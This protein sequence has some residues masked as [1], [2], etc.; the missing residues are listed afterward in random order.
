MIQRFWGRIRE[1]FTTSFAT[2]LY[3]RVRSAT[4]RWRS[5]YRTPTTNW[6]RSDYDYYNRL[7]RG[8]VKGLEVS[9]LLLKPIISK[10]TSW[11]LG[12]VPNWKT[13]NET[14]Q[15][16]LMDWW[17]DHHPDILRAWRDALK[18]GDSVLV[19][20]SDL[21]VTR[22]PPEC[23]DP[24][25]ADDDYA[26]VIGWRVTQVLEHPETTQRMTVI[27]EYYVDRRIHRVE[28]DGT[29]RS[30]ETYPNLLG[31]I[32]LVMIANQ[33]DP[34]EFFGHAEAE[35]LLP[36][37][38]KYGEVLEAAIEGNVL[39]GRPTPVLLFETV[40]DLEKFDEENATIEVQELPDGTSQRVKTYGIDLSQLM[41]ASG[42][43]FK[44]ESPGQFT[45]DV[46]KLLEILFYLLLQHAE[47]PEF[48]FG[49]A[50]PSSKASADAQLAP[51][52]E[53]IKARRGEMAGWLTEIAEIALGYLALVTPGVTAETPM[54]Q[55]EA[56][57][58]DDGDLTLQTLQWAYME[59]LIDRK[60]ALQLAPVEIDNIDQ[61]LNDAERERQEREAAQLDADEQAATVVQNVINRMRQ[62]NNGVEQETA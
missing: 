52:I 62:T 6:T 53:Y 13:E 54:L 39:N 9:A 35:A 15:E 29:M 24:I 41:V 8:Q 23:V 44:Y 48:M 1:F 47:I 34:G 10:L 2:P 22:L 38:H 14:S 7:Y 61:V 11:T 40:D 56:L 46:A 59:G 5:S 16:A 21:S 60:T 17:N 36:L 33:P 45:D 12:V 18:V 51:F 27:D 32:P 28:V 26:N 4:Q 57:D 37:L 3:G 20:N 50:I 43:D 58:Q 25:V 31:R 55:W 49:N 42:A 19:I 30:E